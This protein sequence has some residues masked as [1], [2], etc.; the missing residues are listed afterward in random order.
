MLFSSRSIRFFL[1]LGMAGILFFLS[2]Q[3]CPWLERRQRV[4]KCRFK[5]EETKI[6][7]YTLSNP[8]YI[9][10]KCT[11]SIHNPNQD[12][13]ILEPFEWRMY[14]EDYLIAKGKY[15]KQITIKGKKTVTFSLP[16]QVDLWKLSKSALSALWNQNAKYRMEATLHMNSPLGSFDHKVKLKQGEWWAY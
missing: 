6:Q 14:V 5:L 12:T 1:L 7:K 11:L 13:A 16:I 10:L 4:R 8:R 3:G 2:L 9:Q 15:E